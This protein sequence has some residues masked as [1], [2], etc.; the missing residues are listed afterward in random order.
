MG[1]VDEAGYRERVYELVRRIPRGRVMTYGQIAAILGEGYTAR[2]VGYV[3]HGGDGNNV[4]WQRVINSKGMCSTGRLTLP[5]N[6]QQAMLGSEGVKFDEK[7]RCD[8]TRSHW[9]PEVPT[10][11]AVPKLFDSPE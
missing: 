4:P 2:T 6:M 11:E 1:V 5:H 9:H 7:G 3:M 8:L 10:G